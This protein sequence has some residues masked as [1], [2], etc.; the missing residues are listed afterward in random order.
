[1]PTYVNPAGVTS[2]LGL[3]DGV[4]SEPASFRTIEPVRRGG[5]DV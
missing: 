2:G 5:A 1:M 4:V 3:A